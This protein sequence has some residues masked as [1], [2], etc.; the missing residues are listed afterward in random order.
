MTSIGAC[1]HISN[2]YIYIYIYIYSERERDREIW[3][4]IGRYSE[5]SGDIGGYNKI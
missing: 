4:D 2:I 3:R 1:M 5:V